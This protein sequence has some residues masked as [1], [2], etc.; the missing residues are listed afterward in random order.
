MYIYICCVCIVVNHINIHG[1]QEKNMKG[2]IE[3][4]HMLMGTTDLSV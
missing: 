1:E 3:I 2:N 4:L